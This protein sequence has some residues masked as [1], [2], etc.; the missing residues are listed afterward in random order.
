MHWHSTAFAPA[1]KKVAAT[2]LAIVSFAWDTTMTND[3]CQPKDMQRL[4]RVSGGGFY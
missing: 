2:V 3:K 4:N 1:L